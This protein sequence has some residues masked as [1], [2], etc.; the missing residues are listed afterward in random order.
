MK[1]LFILI[2]IAIFPI[3][4]TVAQEMTRRLP[5]LGP[6][7]DNPEIRRQLEQIKIWQMTKEMD[8]PT[9]KAEKFFPLYNSYD[10]QLRSITTRRKEA[11]RELDSTI[12]EEAGDQVIKKQVQLVLKLDLQIAV[13]HEKF[14]QSL[15]DVLSPTEIGKYIVFEQKFDREIRERIRMVVQ[16][17]MRGRGY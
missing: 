2:S 8:L 14:M 10:T 3:S 16:Q 6:G 11:I 4:W 7:P 5:P 9:N 12:K 15:A 17:R 1:R 13:A